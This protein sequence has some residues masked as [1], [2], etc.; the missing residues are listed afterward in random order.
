MWPTILALVVAQPAGADDA[1]AVFDRMERTVL[2]CKTLHVRAD[3]PD[4][5]GKDVTA[6][7]VVARGNK[8]RLEL[9]VPATAGGR[10][11]ATTVSDGALLR[12]P[13]AVPRRDDAAPARLT[14]IALAAVTR[15]GIWLTLYPVL[16]HPTP[17]AGYKDFDRDR[18]LP[19]S[20]FR[21]GRREPVAGREAQEVGYVLRHQ[22]EDLAVSVWVD[23]RTH[24]PLRRVVRDPSGAGPAGVVLTEAYTRVGVDEKV[25]GTEFELPR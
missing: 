14:D 4:L 25:E 11:T 2:A 23:V 15:G 5:G 21:L 10:R 1:R 3:L 7:L 22:G 13:G 6:R 24:L 17:S 12:T 9:G 20:A 18:D 16:E 8:M 19:V